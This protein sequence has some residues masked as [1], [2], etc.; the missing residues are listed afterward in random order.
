MVEAQDIG[1]KARLWWI[2]CHSEQADPS[3]PLARSIPQGKRDPGFER[4]MPGSQPQPR[5]PTLRAATEGEVR[6]WTG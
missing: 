5:I 6:G 3:I 4:V 1:V 2:P